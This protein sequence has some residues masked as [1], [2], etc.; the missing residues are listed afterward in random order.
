MLIVLTLAYWFIWGHKIK[1]KKAL[2]ASMLPT[3]NII[4]MTTM[5]C[6]LIQ[7]L[8][9]IVYDFVLK[10][11]KPN[12]GEIVQI[13]MLVIFVFFAV[14]GILIN[15]LKISIQKDAKKESKEE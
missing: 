5:L 1:R 3:Y 10:Q 13:T 2:L 14:P 11:D 4:F 7:L 12:M 15:C 6:L 8:I 9:Y